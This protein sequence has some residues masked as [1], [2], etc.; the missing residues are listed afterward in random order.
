MAEPKRKALPLLVTA[1]VA[2]AALAAAAWLVFLAP[3]PKTVTDE[4]TLP[5][6]EEPAPAP[7]PKVT[8]SATAP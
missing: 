5:V 6:P 8:P 3:E 2:L 1:L 7:M 4:P